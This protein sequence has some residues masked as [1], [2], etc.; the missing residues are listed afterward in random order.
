MEYFTHR[1]PE[2]VVT[3]YVVKAHDTDNDDNVV[4]GAVLISAPPLPDYPSQEW[5][6]FMDSVLVGDIGSR[7]VAEALNDMGWTLI[8][9]EEMKINDVEVVMLN[10]FTAANLLQAA[11]YGWYMLNLKSE[12]SDDVPEWID[13]QLDDW[14]DAISEYAKWLRIGV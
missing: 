4:W 12:N 7:T 10:K 3:Y 5:Q 13:G 2:G 14:S 1:L 9:D 11:N 6:E 8:I